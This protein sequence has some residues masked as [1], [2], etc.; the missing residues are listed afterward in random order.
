M[1]ENKGDLISRAALKKAIEQ[2]EGF[3]WDSYGKDDLCVRKK[4][5][6]NAPIVEPHYLSDL[7]DEII[8]SLQTVAIDVSDGFVV[9]ERKRP[10]GEWIEVEKQ[11]KTGDGRIFTYTVVVCSECGEQFDLEG[12]KFC[13]HCGADMRGDNNEQ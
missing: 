10:Q 9:F 3:S 6:D 1:T 7:P 8:K 12:E 2:G 11:G 4:Y 5:I 13:P